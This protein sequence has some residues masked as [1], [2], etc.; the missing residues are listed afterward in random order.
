MNT[1]SSDDEKKTIRMVIRLPS[2]RILLLF[3]T[4]LIFSQTRI[5]VDSIEFPSRNSYSQ[6]ELEP[7][8]ASS[9]FRLLRTSP[10]FLKVLRF[11]FFL[12]LLFCVRPS[13][14]WRFHSVAISITSIVI[15]RFRF[16]SICSSTA[17]CEK[18]EHVI[19]FPTS[20]F[21]RKILHHFCAII[22]QRRRHFLLRPGSS[23][24]QLEI[25]PEK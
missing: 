8:R 20:L 10:F 11:R 16:V 22:I 17:N 4:G 2:E 13:G 18:M 14:R 5:S 7:R 25:H 12:F 1:E 6:A 15:V 21:Q 3:V 9:P 23:I 24:F 19:F